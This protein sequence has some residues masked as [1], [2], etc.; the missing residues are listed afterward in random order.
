MIGKMR[1]KKIPSCLG[2]WRIFLIGGLAILPVLVSFNVSGAAGYPNRSIQIIVA[3]P[4]GGG[5]DITARII[6]VS[7]SAGEG[8]QSLGTTPSLPPIDQSRATSGPAH[9][10]FESVNLR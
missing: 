9:F 6:A 1:T 10:I 8:W 4:P 2:F 5:A 7:S 3:F